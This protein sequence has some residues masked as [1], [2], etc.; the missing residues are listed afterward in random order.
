MEAHSSDA[1]ELRR[2]AEEMDRGEAAQW[3]ENLEGLSPAE[4]WRT[5]HELRVHQIELEMQNDELRRRQAE[6]DASRARYFELYDLAPVGL[7]GQPAGADPGA[8]LTAAG[9]LGVARGALATQ[10]LT[11]FILREDKDLYYLYRRVVMSDITERKQAGETLRQAH[12]ELT[13]IYA[14]VPV[15]LLLV[16]RDLRVIKWNTAV[17][18]FAARIGEDMLDLRSGEALR[19]LQFTGRPAGLRVRDILLMVP[20]SPGRYGH[21]R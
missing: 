1:A 5:L 3:P 15:A 2:R 10:R 11:S 7:H 9:L 17:A 4:T 18:Q 8:N 6:L 16:D 12:A 13:A 20:D 21:L 14:S 19:C